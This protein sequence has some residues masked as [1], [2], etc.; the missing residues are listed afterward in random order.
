MVGTSGKATTISLCAV[1]LKEQGFT[2][3]TDGNIGMPL[4]EYTLSGEKAD[5]VMLESS[6]FQLRT[7]LT[8][9]P[10]ADILLNISGNHPGFH[11]DMDKYINAKM[12]L[13]TNQTE[14]DLAVL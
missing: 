8:L 10:C 12:R 11:K 7:C 5:V 9:H 1:I 14:T 13:F 6:S 4:P 2:V 3:F